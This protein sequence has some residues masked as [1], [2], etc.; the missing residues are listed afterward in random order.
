MRLPLIQKLNT[1]TL[2]V[3]DTVNNITS[4]YTSE[5]DK[6]INEIQVLLSNEEDISP[7]QLNYY[8]TILPILLYDITGKITEL[9][10]KS[11]A[12]KM[13]R[14][15]VFNEAYL[16]QTQGTVSKKTSVA[17]NQSMNEQ[18]VEDVMLRAYKECAS[19]IEIATMLHSS[20]KKVQSW[21]TSEL[22]ITRNNILK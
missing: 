19:K 14:R 5:L 3:I 18:F 10:I 4:S 2:D 17:Q 21:K 9:G 7:Q 12:A 13:Q 1:D 16:E 15:T 11:D 6:C 20:L 8:I 22:E